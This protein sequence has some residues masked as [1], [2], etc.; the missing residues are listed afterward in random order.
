MNRTA[1]C[2][3]FSPAQARCDQFVFAFSYRILVSE[4]VI[5]SHNPYLAI[6]LTATHLRFRDRMLDL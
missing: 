5:V 3:V 4:S 6:R 1:I 2:F